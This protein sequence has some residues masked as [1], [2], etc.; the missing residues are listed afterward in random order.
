M[1]I[2]ILLFCL[3]VILSFSQRPIQNGHP[4]INLLFK[5]EYLV[6][7]IN[8]FYYVK[9]SN[10]NIFITMPKLLSLWL[11]RHFIQTFRV[12]CETSTSRHEY[13]T[14][15]RDR[16]SMVFCICAFNAVVRSSSDVYVYR[17]VVQTPQLVSLH[18]HDPHRDLPSGCPVRA[19]VPIVHFPDQ[20]PRPLAHFPR[21]AAHPSNLILLRWSFGTHHRRI[22]RTKTN[23]TSP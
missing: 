23:T 2:C 11:I 10:N 3:N 4:M 20:E 22:R 17:L 21:A 7:N 19:L 1:D 15:D 6:E 18:E 9:E 16:K 13:F 8:H 12:C 5:Y 14:T